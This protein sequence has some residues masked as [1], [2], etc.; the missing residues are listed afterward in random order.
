MAKHNYD[1]TIARLK[2][3]LRIS[4]TALDED[5]ADHVEACLLDLA[6]TAGVVYPDAADPLILAALKLYVRANYT[7]DTNKAA[8]YMER[9]NA[10]KASLQMAA[11]YG[12]AGNDD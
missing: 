12:G 1:E 3:D 7:D 4:H 5:L 8:A 9:Y 10:M 11:G 2:T 6:V